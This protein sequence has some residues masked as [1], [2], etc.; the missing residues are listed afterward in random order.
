MTRCPPLEVKDEGR[1]LCEAQLAVRLFDIDVASEGLPAA[2]LIK[3]EIVRF[4]KQKRELCGIVIAHGL[5]GGVE[6]DAR[7]AVA[8]AISPGRDPAD[9]ADVNASAVPADGAKENADMA[10]KATVGRLDHHA[11]IGIGPFDMAP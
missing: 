4:A 1:H 9:A 3:F 8:S 11:Q 2:R 6:R 5:H 7:I 10:G